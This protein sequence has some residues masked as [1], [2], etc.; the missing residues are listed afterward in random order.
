[1]RE[2]DESSFEFIYVCATV[3]P[4]NIPSL[5]EKFYQGVVVGALQEM[6]A[7]E[8]RDIFVKDLQEKEKQCQLETKVLPA[9]E[10][11]RQQPLINEGWQG[12]RLTQDGHQYSVKYAKRKH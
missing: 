1:M 3:A 5:K 11:E 7:G 4:R 6:Y 12:I 2:L 10:I 8:M 9:S